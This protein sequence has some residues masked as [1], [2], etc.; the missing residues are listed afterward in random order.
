MRVDLPD[1][2][3]AATTFVDENIRKAAAA[4]S[5]STT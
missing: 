5:P 2:Y 3:N 4:K 1:T